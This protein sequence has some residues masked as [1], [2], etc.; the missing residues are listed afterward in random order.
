MAPE[1]DWDQ[2]LMVN[3]NAYLGIDLQYVLGIPKRPLEGDRMLYLLRGGRKTADSIKEHLYADWF[4]D[5][6]TKQTP[7]HPFVGNLDSISLEGP[8]EE[9]KLRATD[10][11]GSLCFRRGQR[12][13]LRSTYLTPTK[14]WR[15][16]WALGAVFLAGQRLLVYSD[17]RFSKVGIVFTEPFYIAS[18][19]A[20]EQKRQTSRLMERLQGVL[21]LKNRYRR[22]EGYRWFKIV[23]MSR[24]PQYVAMMNRDG[25]VMVEE[26]PYPEG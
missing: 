11:L 4:V 10:L 7:T 14:N 5:E 9:L 24:G 16:R 1:W 22:R 19:N 8:P 2:G 12:D 6:E 20:Q 26:I 25:D 18:Q 23:N 13:F 17:F 21:T 3:L 15:V